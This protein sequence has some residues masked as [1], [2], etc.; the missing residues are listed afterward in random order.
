MLVAVDVRDGGLCRPTFELRGSP[1]LA[2]LSNDGLG[3]VSFVGILLVSKVRSD[4]GA[5]KRTGRPEN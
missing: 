4:Q 5:H 1:L 3:V 2:V